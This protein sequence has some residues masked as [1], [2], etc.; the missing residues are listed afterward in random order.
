MPFVEVQI[1]Q[2]QPVFVGIHYH[3]WS[4]RQGS[5]LQICDRKVM[6]VQFQHGGPFGFFLKWMSA[7]P[8]GA[9]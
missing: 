9:S 6:L 5:R 7:L 1:L 4:E 8:S 2:G 3:R